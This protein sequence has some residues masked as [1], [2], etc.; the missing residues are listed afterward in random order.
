[1]LAYGIVAYATNK[2]YHLHEAIAIQCLKH[3]VRVI[4]AIFECEYLQYPS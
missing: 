4:C 1:M 2:Y 3:F